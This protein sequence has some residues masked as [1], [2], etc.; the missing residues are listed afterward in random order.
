MTYQFN[1]WGPAWPE[2]YCP[3]NLLPLTSGVAWLKAQLAIMSAGG[4]SGR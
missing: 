2:V 3:M 4:R 1:L